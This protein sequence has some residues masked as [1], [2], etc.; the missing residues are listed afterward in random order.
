MLLR[1][2][3][4]DNVMI[5]KCSCNTSLPADDPLVVLLVLPSDP[6]DPLV[7]GEVVL[8]PDLLSVVHFTSA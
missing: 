3:F 4:M 2:H 8:S 1:P 7:V 6:D 5:K